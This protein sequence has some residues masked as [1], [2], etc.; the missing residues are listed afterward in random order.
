MGYP[1]KYLVQQKP[2]PLPR[3]TRRGWL[4]LEPGRWPCGY[5]GY[6]C[7]VVRGKGKK[8]EVGGGR[9]G[10]EEGE[11]KGGANGEGWVRLRLEG[12]VEARNRWGGERGW[13]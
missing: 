12:K 4:R 8:G 11:G 13:R 2:K 7:A 1:F 6:M 10:G 9:K 5:H 3:P